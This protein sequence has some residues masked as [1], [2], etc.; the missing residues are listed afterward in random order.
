MY[1]LDCRGGLQPLE[2]KDEEKPEVQR[3]TQQILQPH[4]LSKKVYSTLLA[5]YKV[6]GTWEVERQVKQSN[7][8]SLTISISLPSPGSWRGGFLRGNVVHQT[9]SEQGDE[10]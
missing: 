8:L 4:F 3:S 10:E 7:L 1:S 2:T 9:D 5:G 6:S